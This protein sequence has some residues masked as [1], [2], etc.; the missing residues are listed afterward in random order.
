[1]KGKRYAVMTVVRDMGM[2]KQLELVS[3]KVISG[4]SP[5]PNTNKFREDN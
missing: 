1:M 3:R 4:N 2:M 5:P